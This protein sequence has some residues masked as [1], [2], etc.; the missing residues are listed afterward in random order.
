MFQLLT[1]PGQEVPPALRLGARQRSPSGW[2]RFSWVAVVMHSS[3][4]LLAACPCCVALGQPDEEE[5][6]NSKL[7]RVP[8]GPPSQVKHHL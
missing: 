5:A 2:A 8:A 4:S 7:M 6:L 1:G 3:R